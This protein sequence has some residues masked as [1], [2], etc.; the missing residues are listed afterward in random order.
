ME[1]IDN[2][3]AHEIRNDFPIFDEEENGKLIYLDNS[4]T[5]Q[6]PVCVISAIMGFYE[7]ENANIQRG[8]YKLGQNVTHLY[9]E[10]H[11][12]VAEFIGAKD[13]EIIFTR[14]ATESINLLSYSLPSIL[15]KEKN[16][17]VLTEEEHHS[18]LIPWQ[19]LAKKGYK[20]KFIKLK[21]FELDYEDAKNKINEKT[22]IVSVS[23]MS[24][25]LGIK[26]NVNAICEMAKK[27]GAISVVD[28]TQAML[29]D[30]IN[31]K[32]IGCDFL[33]FS[34][35]KMFAPTG[36]GVLYGRKELLNNMEPFQTGGSMINFVSFEKS[37]WA[38]LPMKFEAGTPNIE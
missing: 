3:K 21:G 27:A 2:K 10:A 7:T 22:A 23:Y 19:Q 14:S 29:H 28:A 8:L 31:V 26:N 20:L 34:G 30:S 16:E 11:K 38:D 35:H 25:V 37:T 12:V 18:N 17:I 24:N 15:P 1:E 13:K 9:D 6:K 36:I 5:T 4:S 32:E 33:T